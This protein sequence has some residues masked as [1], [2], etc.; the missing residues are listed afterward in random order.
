VA[1]VNLQQQLDLV[2]DI[3]RRAGALAMSHYG[4][5]DRLTKDHA[6]ASNEAVT[7][8]DRA[9]QAQ[10]V[11]ELRALFPGDGFIGEESDDGLGITVEVAQPRG[12]V[13]VIDPIDGTNNFIAGLHDF[14]VCIG[15]LDAGQPVLGVVLDVVR[16]DVY[17][18][19]RGCGAFLNDQPIRCDPRPMN[20]SSMLMMT[21]N[22]LSPDKR[23]PGW[24][25]KLISQIHWK[26]RV[27][28]SAAIEAVKVASGVA[29]AGI[30]CN[31]K[32]W[33]I[34]AAAAIVIEAGGIV[35]DLAGQPLFPFDL[36]GYR[37]AKTPY[38]AGGPVSHGDV[39]QFLREH[40]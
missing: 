21:A 29:G 30:Q 34:A 2:T 12:R 39:L 7:I 15:L 35:T 40:P 1:R 14:C 24:A 11:T 31:T 33:D 27:Q 17:R 38:L 37:G 10:V 22:L 6:A 32:L 16:G 18:R 13:W 26:V 25:V 5:V 4:K 36:T 23:L 8:A 3:A 9:V 28:G 20:E 19:R